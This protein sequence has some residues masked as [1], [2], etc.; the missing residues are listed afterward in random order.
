M[1]PKRPTTRHL[2]ELFGSTAATYDTVIPFFVTFGAR[3]V[4]LVGV[5]A[6]DEVLDV[7]AGRGA[8]LF[9]AAERVGPEGRVVGIDLAPQMVQ[10]LG[11]DI[12]RRQVANATVMLMDAEDI[13]L[14][15]ESFDVVLCGFTLWVLPRPDQA[16]AGFL[17][18]L[19]PGGRVAVSAPTGAGPGWDFFGPLL[20]RFAKD[21]AAAAPPPPNDIADVVARAGFTCLEVLDETVHFT[22]ADEHAW[23][24][25]AWSNGMR[26]GI[27]SVPPEAREQ[28][29]ADALEHVRSLAG[30]DGIPLEQHVRFVLG[31]R[32][33]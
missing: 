8:S 13:A 27:L 22:F 24:D 2:A 18:V 1:P 31:R 19:R 4:E 17:Q 9:P 26:G 3:L 33:V 20:Q 32:P 6:G 30:P 28:L 10:L 21:P 12:A 23:W 29:R 7:A 16:A 25:W 15:A 14:P 5:S 11:D